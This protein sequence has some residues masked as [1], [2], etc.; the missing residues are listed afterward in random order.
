M[1]TFYEFVNLSKEFIEGDENAVLEY[2]RRIERKL[3]GKE[4]L[5]K[6]LIFYKILSNLNQKAM[7]KEMLLIEMEHHSDECIENNLKYLGKSG[8]IER[9]GDKYKLSYHIKKLLLKTKYNNMQ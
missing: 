6:S 5:D 3:T 2:R 8:L 4:I 7:S 1:T 9:E